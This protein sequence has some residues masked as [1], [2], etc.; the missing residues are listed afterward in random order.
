M[1]TTTTMLASFALAVAIVF[2]HYAVRSFWLVSSPDVFDNTVNV[3]VVGGLKSDGDEQLEAKEEGVSSTTTTTERRRRRRNRERRFAEEDFVFSLPPLPQMSPPPPPRTS[4]K[5]NPNSFLGDGKSDVV[6]L[7]ADSES[8]LADE[9]ASIEHDAERREVRVRFK[10][11]RC[12]KPVLR[13]RLSGPA[14]AILTWSMTGDVARGAYEALPKSGTYYLEIVALFCNELDRAMS[15]IRVANSCVENVHRHRLTAKDVRIDII[16][17]GGLHASSHPGIIGSWIARDHSSDEPLYTRVQPSECKDENIPA[18]D[19][20]KRAFCNIFTSTE[21]FN[22]Y[23]FEFNDS[24]AEELKEKV[25]ETLKTTKEGGKA[26]KFCFIGASHSRTLVEHLHALFASSKDMFMA[27][28]AK[29]PRDLSS[30]SAVAS[31][32][33]CSTVVIGI[34]QWAAGWPDG[35]PLSF[36]E[37]EESMRNAL[38]SFQKVNSD[39]FEIFVRSVHENPLGYMISSCPPTDWRNPE[40]IRI[41]NQILGE[42]CTEL[43]VRFLDTASIITPMYDSAGDWCHYGNSAGAAEALYFSAVLTR[44]L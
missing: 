42:I 17:D 6:F 23:R 18:N 15:S 40:V 22:R 27:I 28:E 24:D 10:M 30:V 44:N 20:S 41:Y 35:A 36:R 12:T 9:V 25:R 37:Y 13:G 3:G 14:L 43:D 2:A 16:M 21:R 32:A 4:P 26:I 29:W 11:A 8:T 5:S 19:A 1:T 39:R 34:G 31:E 7:D 38:S 33:K